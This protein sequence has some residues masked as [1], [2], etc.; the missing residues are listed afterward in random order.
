MYAYIKLK[1]L[2][3]ATDFWHKFPMYHQFWQVPDLQH[4]WSNAHAGLSTVLV[5]CASSFCSRI[6]LQQNSQS[7]R[8]ISIAVEILLSQKFSKRLKKKL[9][10]VYFQKSAIFACFCFRARSGGMC[11]SQSASQ[12]CHH[13]C[14]ESKGWCQMR[15]SL[16]MQSAHSARCRQMYHQH[17]KSS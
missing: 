4:A 3:P 17:R 6:P 12:C 15:S 1:L 11:C 14:Q 8:K 5:S 7:A 9:P 10:V 16:A 13:E 2:C